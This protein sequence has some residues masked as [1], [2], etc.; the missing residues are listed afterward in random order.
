[1]DFTEAHVV[2]KYQPGNWDVV[3][4]LL[5][6]LRYV[7]GVCIDHACWCRVDLQ[8]ARFDVAERRLRIVEHNVELVINQTIS[9]E[10]EGS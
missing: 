1:V 10:T 3:A 4:G 2:A 7:T 9:F 6:G 5:S 8:T